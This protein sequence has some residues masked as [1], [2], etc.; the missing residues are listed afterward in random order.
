M[1][2]FDEGFTDMQTY[3]EM[4]SHNYAHTKFLTQEGF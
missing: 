4:S 1:V 3:H 2:V